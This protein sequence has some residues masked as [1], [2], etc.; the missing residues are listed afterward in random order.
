MTFCSIL[1]YASSS[2]ADVVSLIGATVVTY[3]AIVLPSN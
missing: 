1:A 3:Y 2:V